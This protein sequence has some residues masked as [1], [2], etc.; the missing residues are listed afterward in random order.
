MSVKGK[1]LLIGLGVGVGYVLGAKAGRERYEQIVRVTGKFWHSPVVR[2]QVERTSGFVN[3][4]LDDLA[5]LVNAGAK[6]LV[7]RATVGRRQA[8]A[9]ARST[10][11]SAASPDPAA[12]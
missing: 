2:R 6:N 10:G 11:S 7:D 9:A 3:D 4:R 5:T 8:K 1:L 12:E